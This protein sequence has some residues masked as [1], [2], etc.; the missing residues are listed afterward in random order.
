LSPVCTYF[1][2]S[3]FKAQAS[4]YCGRAGS[5]GLSDCHK[6]LPGGGNTAK[7][8][9]PSCRYTGCK[10]DKSGYCYPLKRL[11]AYYALES[12]K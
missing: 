4:G 7:C 10:K 9:K 5:N 3:C 2:G 8:S 11:A 6:E 12:L 1:S